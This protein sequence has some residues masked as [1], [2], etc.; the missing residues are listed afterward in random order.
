MEGS[1]KNN[2][3]V[4]KLLDKYFEGPNAKYKLTQHHLQSY[5]DFIRYKIPTILQDFNGWKQSEVF[6][7]S[8][9]HSAN[10]EESEVNVDARA[11][12]F[13]GMNAQDVFTSCYD[14]T[15]SEIAMPTRLHLRHQVLEYSKQDGKPVR[16][17]TPNEARLR[18]LNY[19]QELTCEVTIV[20]SNAPELKATVLSSKQFV[21]KCLTHWSN[22]F[23]KL[24]ELFVNANLSV[25]VGELKH[26]IK[27]FFPSIIQLCEKNNP[28]L[29]SNLK[30]KI[31]EHIKK[32]ISK[33]NTIHKGIQY[34]CQRLASEMCPYVTS[35]EDIVLTKLPLMLHSQFCV[36]HNQPNR[37][38]R[39]VGE[40][41][42]EKG[43]YFVI[44]GKEKVIISQESYQRNIIQTKSQV[45]T[46]PTQQIPVTT[47]IQQNGESKPIAE[48]QEEI[49]EAVINCSDDP[50]PPV[51]VQMH[52]KR[53]NYYHTGGGGEYDMFNLKKEQ[54]DE[55][56]KHLP[57]QGLYV[58]IKNRKLEN[59][60]TDVP[61]FLL[62][63]AMRVTG[64]HTLSEQISD[65]DILECILGED[66]SGVEKKT[67][68]LTDVRSKCGMNTLQVGE[69]YWYTPNGE[70]DCVWLSFDKG[71]TIKKNA[72]LKIT[73]K[74]YLLK[75]ATCACVDDYTNKKHIKVRVQHPHRTLPFDLTPEK[76]Q[77]SGLGKTYST[78]LV[79][80]CRYAKRYYATVVDVGSK[81]ATLSYM[82]YTKTLKACDPIF[83]ELLKPSIQEGSFAVT[84]ELACDIV[85]RMIHLEA[86]Q[87]QD[88][89]L[90]EITNASPNDK[91][92]ALFRAMF[93]HLKAYSK[94]D[95][96]NILMHKKQ[97]FLGYMTKRLLYAY[98]GL[99]ER[100]TSRDSYRLRRVQLSGEMLGDVF[101]YEYFQLQNKYKEYIRN[102]MR[103][104]GVNANFDMLTLPSVVRTNIFDS[105]Y[106]TDRLQKSFM[107][108]W[109]STVADDADQKAY[110]QELIRLSY[111]GS[112]SYL[113]RVHKEL[114]TTSKPG[115]KKGTSKAVGPR[116]LHA[117]QYGMICPLETPD[118]GNI[119]KIKHLSTFAFV[120]PQIQPSDFNMLMDVVKRFSLHAHEIDSFFKIKQ[121]HKIIIDGDWAFNCPSHTTLKETPITQK[122]VLPPNL[123]VD[124]L[125]VFRRNGLLSPLISIAWNIARQEIII[126]TQEGRVMRPLLIVEH[127]MLLFSEAYHNDV[128]QKWTW[129]ELLVGRDANC[130]KYSDNLNKREMYNDLTLRYTIEEKVPAYE[131]QSLRSTLD[132]LRLQTGVMEYIDT[133]EIDTRMLNMHVNTLIDKCELY[134]RLSL[135]DKK[136]ISYVHPSIQNEN[137]FRITSD[138]L[139]LQRLLTQIE[140]EQNNKT[141]H[142]SQKSVAHQKEHHTQ[143]FHYTHCELHPSLMLGVM[144]MLIP[145]PEHSQAPRNQY[146]C[147]QSKQ[148]LGLYVSSFRKRLDHANHIL[149]YP[150]R[151][152]TGSRYMRYINNERLNYGTNAIVAI[153]CYGGFNI[154]DSILINK[155]SVKRGLFQSSY[156]FTEEVTEK[157]SQNE[158]VYVGR[159]TEI[160][161]QPQNFDYEKVDSN[162]KK[163]GVIPPSFLN[164]EVKENDVLIEAYEEKRDPMGE[165]RSFTDYKHVA[166]K[167]GYVDHIYLSDDVKGR[168]VAKVTLRNVRIPVVGDKIAARTGQKGTIGALIEEDDMPFIGEVSGGDT[169]DA[170][171]KGVK[172]DLILN[173]HAIPSRMTVGQ[174]LESLSGVLGTRLGCMPD[175][176]PLCS[177][178]TLGAMSNPSAT[179]VQIMES[180]GLNPYGNQVMYNGSTGERLDGKVFIGPTYYQRLKQMPTDKYYHRRTGRA[181][182][183]T[184]QPIGGRAQGGALKLGE[185]ERDSLL[186]HGISLFTKEAFNEKSD[187][188]HYQIGR[189]SGDVHPPRVSGKVDDKMYTPLKRSLNFL[190]ND[191]NGGFREYLANDATNMSDVKAHADVVQNDVVQTNIET[192]KVNVPFATRLLSQECEAMGLGMH[193][194][195][196]NH[197]P[198]RVR[199]TENKE[200]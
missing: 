8:S 77:V 69:K 72:T 56:R 152:L 15:T 83:F 130:S 65:R 184:R 90:S 134:Q 123:F 67:I 66:L 160:V 161:R 197:Y 39:D 156:Y 10:I 171:L 37:F 25:S 28:D 120:C 182:M 151:A 141:K 194:I 131:S 99:D 176:T 76:V 136:H 49:F 163:Q 142:K 33:T 68:M 85:Q 133:T 154:E 166:K 6:N 86:L 137:T 91:M 5:S 179:L 150:E 93:T 164:K 29:S 118:G 92:D 14:K 22:L 34:V 185:M 40:C 64:V 79:C 135:E 80:G 122:Q 175:S 54:L 32:G 178:Q 109:G 78:A 195:P 157:D 105:V 63:R 188:F 21:Q 87:T 97:L 110:C 58:T 187:G 55:M 119:G 81:T 84:N 36:L 191:E 113:R 139:R 26:I 192:S 51:T 159:N 4:W 145:F 19:Q 155:Q 146:S 52:Y 138:T 35:Y 173:P 31:E 149:H 108:K 167:D 75:D 62:F 132:A 124:V 101:R 107:G 128:E 23:N 196:E 127:N 168:R 112:L 143:I 102:G 96:K 126:S 17:I 169:N 38:L 158:K 7:G 100:N 53:M 181:D 42:Y 198:T 27:P 89:I 165:G 11:H 60:I 114:P 193:L 94:K 189:E 116:L 148:A 172:P 125:R 174:L 3:F 44:R 18:N 59:I 121:Y 12:I 50:R 200:N 1:K 45:V 153:M 183:V 186:S 106:M 43:G 129:E 71:I 111:Y 20:H 16:L 73:L 170:F 30:S 9:A 82:C 117:S 177:N 13:V 147:H 190:S 70:G 95:T 104:Q 74:P 144:G 48:D 103:Q 47:Y 41:P 140:G 57:F 162:T 199:I 115:Q 61:L 98:L 88:D 180:L 2:E 46:A 24:L